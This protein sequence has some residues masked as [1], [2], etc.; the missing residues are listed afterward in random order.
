MLLQLAVQDIGQLTDIEPRPC[1]A[2]IET[3]VCV[4]ATDRRGR[5]RLPSGLG[6]PAED[7]QAQLVTAPEVPWLQP[8]PD[9]LLAGERA[10]PAE[11]TAS[12]TGIRLAFVAALQ[13][14][15]ARERAGLI[16]RDVLGVP[17][18]EAAD[19]LGTTTT[20]VNSG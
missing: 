11:V 10:D 2:R 20:A 15:S 6:G 5:R 8:F 4:P 19:L 1:L 12:R 18:A 9:A 13:H 3:S 17:A 7:P 14:L 16:L